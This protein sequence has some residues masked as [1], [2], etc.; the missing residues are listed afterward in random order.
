MIPET[1]LSPLHLPFNQ[2]CLDGQFTFLSPDQDPGGDG[3]WLLLRGGELALVEQAD[4]Q[5]LPTGD[6]PA[7]IDASNALYIGQWQNQPCRTLAVDRQ[8][9]LSDRFVWC[10][11]TSPTAEFTIELLT[12][13]GLGRQVLNWHTNSR[14]C[15]KCGM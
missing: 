10:A 5:L 2:T 15:S 13:G 14:F 8:A 3:S 12:L 9:V 6:L 4:R 7:E 1:Y 11:L